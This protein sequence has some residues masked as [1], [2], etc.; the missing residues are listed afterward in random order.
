MVMLVSEAS[1]IRVGWLLVRT[2]PFHSL[3]WGALI[4]TA[5]AASFCG[6]GLFIAPWCVLGLLASQL[7]WIRGGD[8]NSGV[9]GCRRGYWI[10]SQTTVTEL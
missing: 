3:A 8:L 4:V 6:V 5:I 10:L 1:S 2:R 9:I 7:G